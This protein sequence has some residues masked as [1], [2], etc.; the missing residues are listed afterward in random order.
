MKSS[1]AP[2]GHMSLVQWLTCCELDP[3]LNAQRFNCH[4]GS[5]LGSSRGPLPVGSGVLGVTLWPL[6]PR[7]HPSPLLL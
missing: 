4:C 6:S 2:K 3:G 7:G 1:V 5:C